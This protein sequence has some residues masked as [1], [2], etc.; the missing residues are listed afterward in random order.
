MRV[1]LTGATGYIGSATLDALVVAGHEVTCLVRDPSRAEEIEERGGRA[2][3]GDITDAAAVR[4]LAAV[5]DGVV[6]LASP[7]GDTSAWADDVLTTAVLGALAGTGK[8]F[9]TTAGVWDHGSGGDIT[10]TSPLRPPRLTAWRPAITGRVR[11]ATGIRTAVVAPALTYGRGDN[12]LHVVSGSPRTGTG[13]SRA[14][15]VVGGGNS[16]GR[17]CTSTT[18]P[19]STSA[20]SSTPR[21]GPVSSGPP[22]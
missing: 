22:G 13:D 7:G 2:V 4:E 17:Q 5:S 14:L 3:P 16:T 11:A 8:A 6:H 9:V 15:V 18:S 12:L 19:R 21:P 1:L 10:E 20:L